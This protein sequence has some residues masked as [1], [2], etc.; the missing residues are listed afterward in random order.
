V[1]ES[2]KVA[3]VLNLIADISHNFTDGLAIAASFMSGH[4]VGMGTALAVLFH[5]VPH[6]VGDYAILVSSGF[7][8]AQAIKAQFVT[9]LGAFVGCIVGLLFAGK[10]QRL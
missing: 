6:E 1:L 8:Q 7:T 5:E 2:L 9:A 10:C 3:G 4:S